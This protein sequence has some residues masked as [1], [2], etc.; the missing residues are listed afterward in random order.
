[1]R[2]AILGFS[3]SG[4]STLAGF[5][6]RRYGIPVLYLDSV[7]FEANWV[8]RPRAQALDMV[9]A[10]MAQ[11]DWVIDGNYTDLLQAQRLELADQ[12]IYMPF[13]RLSCLIRVIRRYLRFRNTVRGSAAPG[14]TEKI[15]A[16]FIWWVL[17][18]GRTRAVRR[19]FAEIV[20]KYREKTVI[21]RSQ[22]QLRRFMD[23]PV[24]PD[25]RRHASDEAAL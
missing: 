11:P 15:D 3:G 6:S 20:E 10:F 22:R 4:K 2:I 19:H 17:Y 8:P 7:H 12:I 1:M 23:C 9:S 5:L 24:M 13:P 16:E 25:C 21:L 14:C 18:Q